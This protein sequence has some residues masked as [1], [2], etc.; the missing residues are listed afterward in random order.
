MERVLANYTHF[1]VQVLFHSYLNFIV[2]LFVFVFA[3][4][5][6]GSLCGNFLSYFKFLPPILPTGFFL[7]ANISHQSAN[8]Q[9]V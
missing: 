7:Q 6:T 9:S 8:N 2:V 5:K 1:L 4:R 3:T